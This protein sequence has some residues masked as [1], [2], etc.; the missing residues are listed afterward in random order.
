MKAVQLA[1]AQLRFPFDY[2]CVIALGSY[3]RLEASEGAS[4]FEWLLIVDDERVNEQE[5]VVAQA[6]LT[7]LFAEVFGRERLSINKTFGQLCQFSDLGTMVGGLAET[8]RMLT[9]RMLTLTEGMPLSPGDGHERVLRH[10]ASVYANSHTAGHRLLSLATD[11]GRYYRT[12]RASYKHK[13]DEQRKPWAVRAIKNRSYRRFA[14]FSTALDFVARGPR[15]SYDIEPLF[16]RSL[17]AAFMRSMAAPP[18]NRLADALQALEVDATL[19]NDSLAAY[20]H[21]HAALA[22][23]VTRHALDGLNAEDRT[24][25]PYYQTL[26]AKCAELHATL[27]DLVIELPR[28]PRRQLLEMFLL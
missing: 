28:E 5:A 10:L 14:F 3:G 8:N 21:I 1:L 18:I 20:E 11:V 26:R 16:D 7:R 6:D 9:Y 27:A 17:V 19:A 15:I 25:Q 22:S 23:P 12:V 4:D 2:M 24:L 13:V